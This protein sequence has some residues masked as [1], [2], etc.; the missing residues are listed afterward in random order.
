MVER[1][2]HLGFEVRVE[3]VRDDGAAV[4][5]QLTR[6]EADE[7]ELSAGQIVYV[8]SQPRDVSAR[9]CQAS[10]SRGELVDL[11]GQLAGGDVG[12]RHVSR[13]LRAGSRA[14]RST[15]PAAARPSRC[16]RAPRAARRARR[17]AVPRRRGSRRR[18]RS[19]P[20]AAP[21]SSRLR[22]RAGC[23]DPGVPSSSRMF[24][25]NA[26]GCPAPRD[27]LALDRARRPAA[28]SSTAARTA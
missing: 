7:L 1:V 27:P 20:P 12:E 5:A 23:D 26:A 14:A 4:S 25:R 8:R 11:V 2:V 9:G 24:S 3:L 19:P 15:P 17:R 21:A 28:A 6:D 10:G 22:R 13:A 18:G 16:T